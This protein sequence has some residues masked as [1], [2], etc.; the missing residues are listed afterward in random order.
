MTPLELA[1]KVRERLN[2]PER[3]TKYADGRSASGARLGT[4]HLPEA[5]C[6]CVSG[7]AI[8]ECSEYDTRRALY[9]ALFAAERYKKA[10]DLVIEW[11]DSPT[12]THADVLARLDAAI[13]KLKQE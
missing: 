8:V 7:A 13:E 12:T 10:V 2:S 4:F 5:A 3:W 6:W 11:N 9:E 1:V